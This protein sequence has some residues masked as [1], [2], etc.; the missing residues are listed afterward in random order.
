MKVFVALLLVLSIASQIQ[1]AK[2]ESRRL[3]KLP[4][5]AKNA[6]KGS[7]KFIINTVI[8]CISQELISKGTAVINK[9][10][11]LKAVG[12]K[13]VGAP[14]KALSNKI[15]SV[16]DKA[17]DAAIS[18]LRRRRL[19]IFSDIGNG[20]KNAAGA[21]KAFGGQVVKVAGQVGS[22]VQGVAKKINS[23]TGGAL[24]TALQ[25]QVCPLIVTG[26]KQ[27]VT[28]ALAS[29]GYPLGVP[30]C[31]VTAM[32]NGCKAAVKAGFKRYR[33]RLAMKARRLGK[34]P[35]WAKNALKGSAK[36][37]INSVIDCISQE[38][39]SKGT[40]LISKI[41]GLKAVG[42]KLVGAP[43]T[44][45]SNKIKSV[46]DKAVDAAISKLRRR[47]LNIFSSIGNGIKNAAGAVKAFGGQVVK[48]AGQVGTAV[49]GV[50]K[51]I[52]GLTGGKL[53]SA[54]QSVVC[55]LIVK[56]IQQAATTALASIGY[57]LGVPACLV[58]AMTNGCKAAVKAGFKRYRRR[59]AMA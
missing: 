52:D 11:G 23:L 8:D 59:L 49:Q 41:P 28:T 50:A 31:L 3:G 55:P 58:S 2:V 33:R 9:I 14:I 17:I 4:A 37:I 12:K 20:I 38:L 34:L 18:K 57:P 36:F 51:K 54:L 7:S 42:K 30:A 56:G 43:I 24:S 40:A 32:T 13:L 27:A 39:I 35:A 53:S 21:A 6:L 46:V 45:L 15:K 44:A 10:P 1:T 5:W 22:A 26:I 16:V 48:V 19:N 25:N 29:I 47:R